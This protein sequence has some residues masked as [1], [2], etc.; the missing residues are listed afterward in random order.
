M[1]IDD[2]ND[3]EIE[4]ENASVRYSDELSDSESGTDR[5][6]ASVDG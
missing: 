5:Y 3:I 4:G 2:G 1:D 6:C